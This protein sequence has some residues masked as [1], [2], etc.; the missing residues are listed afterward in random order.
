V[1][2]AACGVSLDVP[3]RGA[4]RWSDP[5]KGGPRAAGRRGGIELSEEVAMATFTDMLQTN[6]NIRSEYDIWR[7]LREQNG[8]DPTDWD[9]FREHL[10]R[11]GHPDPGNRPPDD[12]VGEDYKARHADWWANY[13]NRS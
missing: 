1:R 11:I 3:A 5:C 12:W 4:R 6:R 10:I 2:R 7:G 9:A 8:E 13:Q